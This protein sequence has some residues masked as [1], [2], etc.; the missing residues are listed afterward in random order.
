MLAFTAAAALMFMPAAAQTAACAD[1]PAPRLI[2]GQQGRVT[3][4]DPNN[5]RDAAA[6]SGNLIGEIP[7]GA[8]FD[9]LEGPLCA[10]GFNWWRVTYGDL[11]GWTVEGAGTDYWVEPIAPTT[12]TPTPP[13]TATPLPP[14][15]AHVFE[16]PRLIV[17]VLES[18]MQARVINDDP[19]SESISLSVRAVPGV[20]GALITRLEAGDIVTILD[21]V[22]EVD[23]LIWREIELADGRQG[24][25]AEG[26]WNADRSRYERAL[27]AACPYTANRLA[28][29]ID[30]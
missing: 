11:T 21:G 17:N 18:G 16:P 30:R 14:E 25:A 5:V 29:D 3:P 6:R 22:E 26:F 4:G 28:F 7:G 10:D 15:P 27:L 13:P 12:P 9:V 20:D 8:I 19:D 1:A 23:S 2:V 24:W